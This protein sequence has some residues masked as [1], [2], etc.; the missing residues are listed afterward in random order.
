MSNVVW[1]CERFHPYIYGTK[2]ELLTDHKRLEAIYNPGSRPSA[3]VE[4]WTLR[5]QPYDFK[6][7]YIPG[8]QNVAHSLS[9]LLPPHPKPAH[10]HGADEY[11]QFVTHAS[12]LNAVS[13]REVEEATIP[14][15][16][17]TE[18]KQ[19]IESGRFGQCKSYM[20]VAGELCISGQLVLRGTRIVLP[21]KLCPQA[22]ALGHEGHLGIVGTKQNLRSKVYWPGMDKATEKHFKSCHGCQLGGT[23]QPSRTNQVNSTP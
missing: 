16:E 10:H 22:L 3:H 6:V 19:A 4:G 14:D 21:S 17:L 12:V 5:L 15:D 23:T 20:P 2:F 18:V 13:L 8:Q 1:A 7:V 11:V 9:R